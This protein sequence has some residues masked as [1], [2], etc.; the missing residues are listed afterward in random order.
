MTMIKN[1]DGTITM[2]MSE[3]EADH[4][5]YVADDMAEIYGGVAANPED[6]DDETGSL[7]DVAKTLYDYQSAMNDMEDE[8]RS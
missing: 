1:S 2:T 3:E 5:L 8:G 6:P 4:I 7:E